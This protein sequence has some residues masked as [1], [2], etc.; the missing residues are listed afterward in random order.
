VQNRAIYMLTIQDTAGSAA[1]RKRIWIHARTHP[2]EV[3]G[4]WVTNEIIAQLLGPATFARQM[5]NGCIFNIIPM[6]NPDG[7]ELK[8]ARQNANHIDIES[9]WTAVPGEPEVQTLRR[10][11]VALMGEPNPINI[12]LNMHSAYGTSRYFVYHTA[13]GTSTAYAAIEERFINAARSYFPGGIRPYDYF[14]SW[15]STPALQYP[16]SWF[17]QNHRENVLALTYEDM[18]DPS[19]RAFD[20]TANALLH[21]IADELA[22][23]AP[24]GL[25]MAENVPAQIELGQNWPNPFNPR[26]TIGIRQQAVGSRWMKLAVYDL[27]GREVAVL[28][29][30]MKKHGEYSVTWDARGMASGVYL[31][32]LQAGDQVQTRKMIL[33]R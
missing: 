15:T 8:L 18:N 4:T 1:P 28:V 23:T 2:N 13:A 5:R 3:Q 33:L 22:I 30:E 11:F 29:D 32:R 24:T 17:W 26:T 14:V 27:L 20:S 16:E 7:V 6:I 31:C 10:M 21:G 9:N 25:P 12:A 19:A